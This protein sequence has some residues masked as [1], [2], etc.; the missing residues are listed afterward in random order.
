MRQSCGSQA[1]LENQGASTT[2]EI[3]SDA[4]GLRA[5]N[6]VSAVPRMDWKKEEIAAIFNAPLL[7]LIFAA[8]KFIV[9]ATTQLRFNSAPCCPSRPVAVLKTA[10]IV[11]NLRVTIPV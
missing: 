10:H 3:G 8:A 2:D 9:S 4:A 5:L 1:L 7:E 11:R 6:M